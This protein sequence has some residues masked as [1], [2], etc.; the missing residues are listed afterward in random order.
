VCPVLHAEPH[1]R[2][3]R[4]ERLEDRRQ[5]VRADGWRRADDQIPGRALAK[6]RDHLPSFGDEA[7]SALCIGEEGAARVRELHAASAAH[8]ELDS[9]L[10]LQGLKSRGERGLREEKS[11]RGAAHVAGARHFDER[12]K[13]GE[14][15]RFRHISEVYS[16]HQN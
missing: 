3:R 9:Q 7:E 15:H 8:E 12:L 13:V 14:E 5:Q 10:A 6:I 11:L 2:K 4:A 1:V 16:P